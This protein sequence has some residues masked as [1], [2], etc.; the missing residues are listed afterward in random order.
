[1]ALDVDRGKGG[2]T[3]AARRKTAAEGPEKT[4]RPFP[5][6][7]TGPSNTHTPMTR[8]RAAAAL[9]LALACACVAHGA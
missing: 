8:R 3:R 7:H 4:Q 5:R 9:A 2:E 6:T 1:M